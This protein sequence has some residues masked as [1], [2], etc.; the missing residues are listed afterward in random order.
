MTTAIGTNA[1][2]SLSAYQD[3]AALNNPGIK[4][5]FKQYEVVMEKAP[6]VKSLP[7]PSIG[8]GYFISAVET[9]VGP[10]QAVFSVS[11]SFP[12][13]G[14]LGAQE[15][16]TLERAKIILERF[17]DARARLN[18]N[19]ADTYNKLYVL[20]AARRITGENIQ[21]LT[22]FKDLASIRFEAGKGSMVDVLRLDM[23]LAELKNTLL[24]LDDS[25]KPLVARFEELLNTE[26]QETIIFPD[27]L[28]PDSL[29]LPRTT[30]RDS[31]TTINPSLLSLEHEILSY[32]K[33]VLAAKKTGGPSFTVGLNYTL[34][35]DNPGYAGSDNGRD[36]LLPTLGVKIPLYRK[37]YNALVKEKELARESATLR[38]ED[39]A[40]ELE[41]K[42]EQAFRDYADAERRV[43]LYQDLGTYAKQALDILV[44]D[45]TSA[46]VAFEEIIRMDRKLLKYRLELE[47]ARADQSTVTAYIN[48]LMGR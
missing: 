48:Y 42:L 15:E 28:Q 29:A 13:F 4:A 38:R 9:R 23:E 10:Q 43:K 26:L 25:R 39:K 45:Y 30:I 32:D 22:T 37:N 35:A 12:W 47:K 41:T 3:S 5:L 6:Q 11:Q 18:F 7:D 8:F 1:Q 34:V 36:A 33:D 44:A 31:V 20:E 16:A 19:V 14:K 27:P 40:N 46:G 2:T 24:Y 17:N 21:L